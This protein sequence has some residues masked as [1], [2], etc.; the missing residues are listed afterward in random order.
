MTLVPEEPEEAVEREVTAE[1]AALP[2]R[3]D[4]VSKVTLNLDPE[5][6]AETAELAVRA[7]TAELRVTASGPVG[8][9]LIQET[10]ATA[11]TAETAATAATVAT[12]T[13]LELEGPEVLVEKEATAEPEAISTPHSSSGIL[14]M[15]TAILG[16][17]VRT[18]PVKELPLVR[19][20]LSC[21]EPDIGVYL[22]N[23]LR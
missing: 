4:Q 1:T 20:A 12:A 5:V 22:A 18:G 6:T 8:L 2:Y 11:A 16:T 23:I 3:Q 21:P 9:T 14:K 15:R 17:L 10:A 7:E 13:A 19:R